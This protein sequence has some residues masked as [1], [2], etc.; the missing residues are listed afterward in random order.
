M[1]DSELREIEEQNARIEV[2]LGDKSRPDYVTTALFA[3]VAN[4]Q[5]Q[6][7][8]A[9]REARKEIGD[10]LS[11]I[12]DERAAYR[13]LEAKYH[14]L[15]RWYVLARAEN[16][17]PIDGESGWKYEESNESWANW[18]NTTAPGKG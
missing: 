12:S 3:E 4:G 18:S 1:T 7:L 17:K 14:D 11:T 5:K 9:L 16:A 6:L 15:A 10:L 8:A 13:E 2:F